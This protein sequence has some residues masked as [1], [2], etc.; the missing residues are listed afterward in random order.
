MSRPVALLTLLASTT[1]GCDLVEPDTVTVTLEACVATHTPEHMAACEPLANP[2]TSVTAK[3]SDRRG[4]IAE[5]AFNQNNLARFQVAAG[6]YHVAISLQGIVLDCVE[7][8]IERFGADS[9]RISESASDEFRVTNRDD[10]GKIRRID[11]APS[12]YRQAPEMVVMTTLG[13]F[14][15]DV[16]TLQL[17]V[18]EPFAFFGRARPD[19]RPPDAPGVVFVGRIEQEP[20]VIRCLRGDW[21]R[22]EWRAW[23]FP[24]T[25]SGAPEWVH[26]TDELRRSLAR[27]APCMASVPLNEAPSAGSGMGVGIKDCVQATLITTEVGPGIERFR[28]RRP[29][30]G[31]GY[32]LFAYRATECGSSWASQTKRDSGG[33]QWPE[34]FPSY[35]RMEV[36]IAC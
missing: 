16:D 36:E 29:G 25:C 9:T 10:E 30:W 32:V 27:V 28:V 3:L 24:P 15:T 1:I 18:G 2:P 11:C 34:P 20:K 4:Q 13:R 12:P 26:V 7:T 17:S 19:T 23:G 5:L 6:T 33:T 8:V 31:E 21:Y 22:T 14:E 35:A